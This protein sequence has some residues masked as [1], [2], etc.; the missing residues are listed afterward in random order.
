MIDP[1]SV[2][3]PE[4]LCGAPVGSP[5]PPLVVGGSG[6]PH[7]VRYARAEIAAVR[8]RLLPANVVALMEDV[9]VAGQAEHGDRWRT[10]S[11]AH[12]VGKGC[13]HAI[14]GLGPNPIDADS[15]YPHLVLGATRLV[16]AV[17]VMLSH[18]RA[19]G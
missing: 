3:C 17:A 11:A 14:R 6:L 4:P 19:A 1:L 18:G 8:T 15:G 10:R 5:C 13:S 12:H 2:A 7:N 16:L 9:L